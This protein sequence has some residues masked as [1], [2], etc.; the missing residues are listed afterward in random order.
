MYD[1]DQTIFLKLFERDNYWKFVAQQ[2]F[3]DSRFLKGFKKIFFHGSGS[4]LNLKLNFEP[5]KSREKPD[6]DCKKSW[7]IK[8]HPGPQ[9]FS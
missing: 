5:W 2:F 8:K 3:D 1:N 9:T 6:K 7:T 4:I